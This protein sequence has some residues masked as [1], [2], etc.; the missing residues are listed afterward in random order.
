MCRFN[1]TTTVYEQNDKLVTHSR[2]NITDEQIQSASRSELMV[3]EW[4]IWLIIAAAFAVGE[5]ITEGFFLA[6]FAIGAASA[7]LAT[8][9]GFSTAWQ[10]GIFIIV[11]GGLVL[12]SRQIAERVTKKQPPGIG[13]DRY[14]GK[15]G[16][17]LEV[18]DNLKNTGQ[19]RIGKEEWRADSSTD[20]IIPTGKRVRV[21]G[22]D[23]THLVVYPLEEVE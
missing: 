14:I 3:Q 1:P 23:G 21:T 12:I 11:S 9:L 2:A 18:V 5:I 10:W 15:T 7:G 17:V 20:E 16:V 8:L 4:L 13:A 6:W 19:V 22:L